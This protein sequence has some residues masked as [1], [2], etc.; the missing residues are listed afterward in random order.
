M[1]PHI[2]VVDDNPEDCSRIKRALRRK[3][4]DVQVKR[5]AGEQDLVQALE[6]NQFDLAITDF[7][8]GWTDG[9]TVLRAVKSHKPD[10][11]VIMFTSTGSEDVAVEAMKAG[12]DDYVRKSPRCSARLVAAVRSALEG[13]GQRES[14]REGKARLL[15]KDQQRAAELQ[16]LYEASLH[17][18]AQL[19]TSRVLRLIAEQAVN[20]LEAEWSGVYLYDAD[21]SDLILSSAAG[22][23]GQAMPATVK[24]GEGL[25]GRVFDSRR[26]LVAADD[27]AGGGR[28]LGS[29]DEKSWL[30]VPLMRNDLVL[31]V[32]AAASKTK[33]FDDHAVWLAELF[34]AQATMALQNA[35]IHEEVQIRARERTALH[36]AG[37]AI[38]ATLDL[39]QVLQLVIA[40]VKSLVGAEGATVLLRDRDRGELYFAAAA[41]PG[42][43]ELLGLRLPGD[44]GVAGSVVR[45]ARSVLVED[46]RRDP[47]FYDQV[48]AH[49][50]MTT[51][52]MVAVPLMIQGVAEGVVEA[53]NKADGAFVERD[54]EVL[55]VMA[56][57]AAVAIANA[58]L[59]QAEREQFCRLQQ[60]QAQLIQAEKMAA[61]GRLV[62][63][64]AH[65]INNPLQ[66][67]QGCLTL[68]EEELEELQ[69][70]RLKRYLTMADTEMQR[71]A[72]IVRRV[73]DFYR[74]APAE[75]KPTDIHAVLTSLLELVGKQL[76]ENN[77]TV[78]R[79]WA[80]ELPMIEAN[81]SY[82]KQV[83]LNLVLN[84]VDAMSE[85]GGTLCV[86]TSLDQM[87]S[88][89]EKQQ[90]P[91]V[92]IE[93]TDTGT[94]MPPE[95]MAHLFEPFVTAK[96][97][98]TGLGLS[99]S[100][101]IIEAH[102]GQISATSQ[103]GVGS[104]FTVMLPVSEA[105][106]TR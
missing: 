38:A 70:E 104:S 29:G 86:R 9:L 71:I 26:S 16:A 27:E 59:Y 12:L 25:T 55:E 97:D 65:E 46:A 11:P 7:K 88:P 19:K 37:Q 60:S 103:V 49:T 30:G 47:R 79:D 5:V 33:S 43:E 20:L 17:L 63:S 32:L 80:A 66:A 78:E 39:D 51:R 57:S 64:I 8:L 45:N 95:V 99:I 93:F 106:A 100:Y 44:A 48:D 94:G 75:L 69:H 92:R 18:N 1:I 68:A 61:M 21:R 82:L 28:V 67:V 31:G 50:G 98:G 2:L 105:L 90:T 84:A 53:I 56:G 72:S 58:R 15:Q 77:V 96:K 87:Q 41:G 102:D 85:H 10:C 101:G 62:A 24:P 54:R 40:E 83:F 6:T 35:H 91:A 89:R 52:S 34:A 14:E 74:P 36:R 13:A 4:P 81:P 73:R 76:Q 22:E 23:L 42:S 3:F